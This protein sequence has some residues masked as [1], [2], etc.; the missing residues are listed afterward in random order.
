MQ[1]KW[2]GFR[3]LVAVD[4]AGR[5]RAWSRHGTS[6]TARLGDLLEGFIAVPAAS[7][8]DGE[9]VSLAS[10]DGH[11]VQDFAA[12]GRIKKRCVQRLG[13]RRRVP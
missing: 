5:V 6:L 9:L 11:V 2:D 13:K 8:F 12:V 10:R 1:P 7:V 4:S 3:L